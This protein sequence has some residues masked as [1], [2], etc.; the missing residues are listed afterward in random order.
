MGILV[1]GATGYVGSRLVTALLV[2][3]QQVVAASRHPERL[4][5]F[6]WFGDI[7][8]VAFDA[9][10]PHHL[11]DSDPGW[12]GGDA[13]RIRRLARSITPS[14]ARPGLRLVNNVPGPLAGALRTGLDVLIALTPKVHQ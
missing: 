2:E 6:G 9:S 11:A 10:D 12:A 13:L 7:T 8:P 4:K 5:G 3:G 1:T 14:I